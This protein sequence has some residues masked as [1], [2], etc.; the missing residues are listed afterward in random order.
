MSFVLSAATLGY[1]GYAAFNNVRNTNLQID[2]IRTAQNAEASESAKSSLLGTF[3]RSVFSIGDQKQNIL[4]PFLIGTAGLTLV[5]VLSKRK[6]K[7]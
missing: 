5:L 4:A 1:K 3:K 6:R 2:D 7:R